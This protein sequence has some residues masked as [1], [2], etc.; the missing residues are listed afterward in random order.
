MSRLGNGEVI[1]VVKSRL[2][3]ELVGLAGNRLHYSYQ[4]LY[5]LSGQIIEVD[6][7]YRGQ[8]SGSYR[9]CS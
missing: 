7:S 8:Y 4:P 1:C 2:L 3:L 5:N 9:F 6:K